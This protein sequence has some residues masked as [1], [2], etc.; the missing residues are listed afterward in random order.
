MELKGQLGAAPA[1][2]RLLS[3]WST[4]PFEVFCVSPPPDRKI[5]RWGGYILVGFRSRRVRGGDVYDDWT[6]EVI[7]TP[8]TQTRL[9]AAWWA[10]F[11][12]SWHSLL[13]SSP[14]LL[15]LKKM[16]WQKD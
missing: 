12:P 10:L 13:T 14:V 6:H 7:G 1:A 8:T 16:A 2:S 3:S 4:D 5:A 9:L 15:F 11:C